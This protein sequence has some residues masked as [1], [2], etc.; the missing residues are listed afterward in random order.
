[1]LGL[2]A[3]KYIVCGDERKGRYNNNNNNETIKT[4]I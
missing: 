1:M 4:G 3:K 2:A